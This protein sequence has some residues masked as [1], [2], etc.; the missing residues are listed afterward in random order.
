MSFF[1]ISF[2]TFTLVFPVKLQMFFFFTQTQNPKSLHDSFSTTI[3]NFSSNYV[4]GT[5]SVI[6]LDNGS[7]TMVLCTFYCNRNNNVLL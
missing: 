2:G 4:F 7:K 5:V 6:K 3:Y 1:L